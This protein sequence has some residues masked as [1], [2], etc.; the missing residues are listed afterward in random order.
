MISE[1]ASDGDV[2]TNY[3]DTSD[4]GDY[5]KSIRYCNIIY[6]TDLK[7]MTIGA[8]EINSLFTKPTGSLLIDDTSI[9]NEV[10]QQHY[11]EFA[12]NYYKFDYKTQ[13][14]IFQDTQLQ[15]ID[16]TFVSASNLV[17]GERY[18]SLHISGS[19]NS[20][21]YEEVLAWSSTGSNIPE[22]SY[23]TS[24]Q[25][26]STASHEI[27]YN[28]IPEIVISGS[29]ADFM[30]GPSS[31]V[32]VHDQSENL[33]KYKRVYD[34]NTGIDSFLGESASLYPIEEINLVVLGDNY[35]TY[36]LDVEEADT[37]VMNDVGV[38]IVGHNIRYASQFDSGETCFLAGTKIEMSDGTQ[39]NIE[40]I[41]VGDMVLSYDKDNDTFVSKEVL[42]TD[43]SHNYHQRSTSLSN[44]GRGWVMVNSKEI[45]TQ[46]LIEAMESGSFYSSS[47]IE[48][49]KVKHNNNRFVV[50]I[51]PN[52][53]V[54]Y[55]IS[56]IG[57]RKGNSQVQ[58]LKRVKGNSAK[59]IFNKNDLFVRAK[60]SS[61]QIKTNPYVIGET[62][63]AWTQ[64][65]IVN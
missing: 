42:A 37:Y 15:N 13:G 4:G 11:F 2:I 35:S 43:D 17:V 33:L 3:V 29:T 1:L 40:D 52:K 62:T 27:I 58:V 49:K 50:E 25:L 18:K 59:Y 32:L 54:D 20:D 8:Y 22:N 16:G 5:M 57:Y 53:G 7:N 26:I 45:K 6:D 64:P 23:Y 51:E 24:S 14:G 19:S 34:L 10:H 39:R 30:I 60:I 63:Q 12:T 48:L 46:S 44:T 47:G 41:V 55:E 9:I 38:R 21:D 28:V 36:E 61:D 31:L 56:F 65:V